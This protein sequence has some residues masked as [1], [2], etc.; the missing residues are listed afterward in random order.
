MSR[1]AGQFEHVFETTTAGITIQAPQVRNVVPQSSECKTQV[2][3][4]FISLKFY[5]P[6]ATFSVACE[7]SRPSSLPARPQPSDRFRSEARFLG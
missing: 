1:F 4:R 7:N 2:V 5:D 3:A 6:I